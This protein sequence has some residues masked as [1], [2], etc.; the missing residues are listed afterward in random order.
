M[1]DD[2]ALAVAQHAWDIWIAADLEAFLDLWTEDG[3]WTNQGSS[4]IS[5]PRRGREEIAVVARTAFEVSGGT[6][7][8]RPI[9]LADAGDGVVLGWFHLEAQREGASLDQDGLQ[10]FVIRNG[11]IAS[12][13]NLYT[14]LPE[15]DA[16]YA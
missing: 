4:Q 8:A 3:V 7:K 15:F 12:L 5:G 1:A 2:N 10:R 16:F 6:L 11:K 14:N 13:D 9:A